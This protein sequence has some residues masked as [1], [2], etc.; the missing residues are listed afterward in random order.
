MTTS[1]GKAQTAGKDAAGMGMRRS[2]G[3]SL[4]NNDETLN[5]SRTRDGV[6]RR[7]ECED[8][9][10]AIALSNGGAE[11]LRYALNPTTSSWSSPGVETSS[12][13]DHRADR[14]VP[15]R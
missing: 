1:Y 3:R 12:D 15:Q 5:G 6:L 9:S 2:S 8:V 10:D 14:A 13:R 11:T 4:A 7:S